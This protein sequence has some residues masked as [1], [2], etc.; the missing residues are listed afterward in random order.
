MLL[1]EMYPE[2]RRQGGLSKRAPQIQLLSPLRSKTLL[3]CIKD[4]G[5]LQR[6]CTGRFTGADGE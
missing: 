6:K 5:F 4:C 1:E 2:S 3:K